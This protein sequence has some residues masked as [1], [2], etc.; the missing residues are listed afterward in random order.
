MTA[1]ASA[2]LVLSLS[3]I[4]A[5]DIANVGGKGANLG[6]LTSAG[7]PIPPGFCVTTSAFHR[8]LD[9]CPDV[10]AIFARL[11]EVS[12]DDLEASSSA[13]KWVRQRLGTVSMS[14][15]V[16][17]AIVDAWNDAGN[18][19]S[20]AVRS[21]ATAE[22][23]P[24]ASFAGQQD[25]FLNVQGEAPL[26]DAV[27]KC[28]ISLFTD[29]ANLYRVRNGFPHCDVLVAVVIQRMVLPDVS[30]ILFT[31]DPVTGR[32]HIASIDASFGLGEALVAG[33]ISADLYTVDKLKGHVIE[34]RIARKTVAIQPLTE[35]GT[36]QIP[37]ETTQITAPSL[38]NEQAV[39]LSRLGALIEHHYGKPQDI[40]WA[41]E[42]GAIH[43]LQSRPITSLFPIPEAA[44]KTTEA[45]GEL[46]MMFSFGAVQGLLG[47]ITILGQDAIRGAFA[48]AG[49]LFGDA[50]LTPETQRVIWSAAERIFVNITA[51]IRHPIG[52]RL[53][54][55]FLYQVEPSIAQA[56]TSLWDD[57]RLTPEAG[58]F[59]LRTLGRIGRFF[60]PVIGRVLL[61]VRRPEA[62]REQFQSQLEKM[63]TD[64][65]GRSQAERSLAGR[66]AIF[67]EVM[68]TGFATILPV[69]LPVMGV[70]M[71][72]LNLLKRLIQNLPNGR[73]DALVLT[74]GLPHN[75]TTEMDMALW[76]T[77][78]NILASDN[79]VTLF[80][81]RSAQELADEFHAR[82]LPPQIHEPIADFLERYGMRGVGEID[83]GRTRWRENPTPLLQ[84]LQSFVRIQDP[85]QA[86]D[87]VYAR[88]RAEA[89]ASVEPLLASLHR[90]RLGWIKARLAKAA[91]FR[92]RALLGLRE[93]PKF[94]IIRLFGFVRAGLLESGR[95]LAEAGTLRVPEDIFFLRLD[96]LKSLAAGEEYNWEA[97]VVERKRAFDLEKRRRLIPRLLLS[98]G[99]AFYEGVGANTVDNVG[100]LL[101]SPV[102][103]GVAEGVVRLIFD[104][105][106]ARLEPGE[107]LVC[108]GTDPAWTPLFLAAGG[109]VMEVGG[110]M[111]HGSVVAREYGI[112]AVAGVHE[113][114]TRL[115][116][117]QAIRVDGT[118]G[119]V[120]ILD[121]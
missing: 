30:G 42:N 104:P 22:D 110:L 97:L 45:T 52:R 37:L 103:P 83:I 105:H 19:Y 75:V 34:A 54:R 95:E 67:E 64:L 41:I 76:A 62:T 12:I 15:G 59:R 9:A 13:G 100:D 118:A 85:R 56:I 38:S 93:S 66:V 11:E 119:T 46:Q 35:G 44:I 86:P 10:D 50:D 101:G 81:E 89:E 77:A 25:T 90:T 78:R 79:A 18:E 107:I 88:G 36:T 87:V 49:S 29:R 23:L 106:G 24:D 82:R 92:M 17:Q 40:E 74:R 70:G 61:A 32:R 120:S 84:V 1:T 65:S 117:G 108:P 116:T 112:P 7:F 115:K 39:E 14:A 68:Q 20:Y 96:E 73:H 33:L 2:A 63:A 5:A 16:R 69:F 48:G 57:P 51:V 102:S 99:H 60:L 98:D 27:Q 4:G 109:L 80:T 47:P 8:F 53:M 111:T 114:T 28:W 21:S 6:E 26:L 43:I 55:A 113:A 31:A 58:W 94:L 121:D 91:I 3:E 72:S 71:A